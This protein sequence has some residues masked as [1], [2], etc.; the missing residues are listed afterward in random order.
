M[1]EK[2]Y[3]VVKALICPFYRTKNKVEFDDE[4]FKE[5]RLCV[6]NSDESYVIDVFHGLKY[7]YIKTVNGLYYKQGEIKKIGDRKRYAIYS[8]YFGCTQ[9]EVAIANKFINLL[10]NNYEFP[11]GNEMLDN[12]QYYD[13][14]QREKNNRKKLIKRKR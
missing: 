12:I 7:Q 11:D 8:N 10:E 2:K 13:L 5:S 1:S 9:E 3:S 6:I 14:I 4:H